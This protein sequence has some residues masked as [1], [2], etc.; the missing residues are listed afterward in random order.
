MRSVAHIAYQRGEKIIEEDTYITHDYRAKGGVVHS[1]IIVPKNA[2]KE[3]KDSETLWNAVEK[4]EKR[5][6]SQLAREII[7]AIP[8]EFDLEAQIA[9]VGQYVREN[10]VEKGMC[11]DFSIHDEG[12]GNPHAHIMLTLRH[13]T[14]KGFGLK[15]TAWNKKSEHLKWRKNWAEINNDLFKWLGMDE[16]I[17]H[18]SY[19]EQGLD[20]EPMIHLGHKA[21]A[22]EKK[23]VKTDRGNH[24]RAVQQRNAAREQGEKGVESSESEDNKDSSAPKKEND[25]VREAPKIAEPW[26]KRARLAAV[27]KMRIL[28]DP[29]K[30]QDAEGNAAELAEQGQERQGIA[31]FMRELRGNFFTQE[32]EYN[33]AKHEGDANTRA[34]RMQEIRENQAAIVIAYHTQKL[35]NELRPDRQQIELLL[36]E[37]NTPPLSVRDKLLYEQ[38]DR[39]LN[40]ITDEDFQR[41]IEN[42]PEN[43]AKLLIKERNRQQTK[44]QNETLTP[45]FNEKT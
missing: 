17:D 30:K 12:K 6:D 10:F 1:E 18:R 41:V 45:K 13:V 5:K 31:E 26:E 34:V 42:L 33:M 29:R 44:A 20:K 38:I 25:Q 24:N 19:K 23:G 32:K 8:R 9:V 11:A 36:E 27:R 35:F 37:M 4:S 14:R 21:A 40:T 15:N 16:R 22:L 39:R 2:P 28:G 7:V 3:F 43:D